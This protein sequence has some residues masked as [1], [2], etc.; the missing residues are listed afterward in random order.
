MSNF[1][2]NRN[3]PMSDNSEEN[4]S[5]ALNFASSGIVELLLQPSK[6]IL[7]YCTQNKEK[8][9]QQ[10][11]I[12]LLEKI[13]EAWQDLHQKYGSIVRLK[14]GHDIIS[15]T[16]PEDVKKIFA[17]EGKYPQRPPFEALQLYRRQCNESQGLIVGS[18]EE[19]VRLRQ[20][21][22]WILHPKSPEKYVDQQIEVS[23]D[24]ITRIRKCRSS[25]FTVDDFLS[26]LYLFTQE[27]IGVVLF[28]SRLGTFDVSSVGKEFSK[29]TDDLLISFAHTFLKFPW[30]KIYKTNSYKMME[31]SISFF[32]DV[33]AHYFEKEESEFITKL[34]DNPTLSKSDKILL[35]QELFTAGI[36]ATGNA[37]CFLLHHL[38]VNPD[39]QEI[40]HEEIVQVLKNGSKP[41][42]TDLQKN[43]PYLS[44]C[45]KESFRLTP[46][47]G[48][49]IRILASD[50]VLSGF[51]V[52]AGTS[53]L[54]NSPVIGVQQSY[55][56]D[57]HQ[58]K[59][60]RW[61]RS[62]TAANNEVTK[63]SENTHPYALMPFGHGKRK[64]VG[65]RFADQ[66][67]KLCILMLL[68]N[69]KLSL[70]GEKKLGIKMRLQLM[71]D[72]PLTFK[73]I[74]R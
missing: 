23:N 14:L 6:L 2:R 71:P 41:S 64:C 32:R 27:S 7:R 19:W 42:F 38:C 66:E 20:A 35:L 4:I 12:D 36:D 39:I 15:T 21:V 43:F 24:F 34:K 70:I 50:A 68:K 3:L 73:F 72:R 57:A 28:G 40:L 60:E 29:Q 67:M 31:S 51:H 74:D 58:F 33:S 9:H 18:G 52:P 59:P 8:K 10:K 49:N 17:A 22:N 16:D 30:W 63:F 47:A 54:G 55:F 53:C 46:T 61:L 65:A 69:F 1:T 11:C 44:A 26:E 48:G 13:H 62:T 56:Q 25:E 5:S 37:I 45:I